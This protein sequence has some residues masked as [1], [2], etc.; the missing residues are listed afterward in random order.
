MIYDYNTFKFHT[1]K[2][3]AKIYLERT[4]GGFLWVNTRNRLWIKSHNSKRI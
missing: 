4:F 3:S 2:K 1:K